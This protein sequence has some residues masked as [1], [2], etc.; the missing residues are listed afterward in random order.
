MAQSL[1]MVPL[2]SPAEPAHTKLSCSCCV[3]C[4]CVVCLCGDFCSIWLGAL[5]RWSLSRLATRPPLLSPPKEERIASSPL[6]CGERSSTA[7]T[8]AASHTRHELGRRKPQGGGGS[9]G[10]QNAVRANSELNA[11][12][13][14]A[15]AS[16]QESVSS[17]TRSAARVC[18]WCAATVLACSAACSSSWIDTQPRP[19]ATPERLI[20]TSTQ[21]SSTSSRHHT[22]NSH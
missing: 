6:F 18:C 2:P 10:K 8:R 17:P 20:H 5:A 12:K 21:R 1:P 13:L 4:V 3:A 9:S 19:Q 7:T 22:R 15:A 11:Q 14:Q 16:K